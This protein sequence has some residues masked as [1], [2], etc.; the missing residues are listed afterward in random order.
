MREKPRA[1]H[2]VILRETPGYSI[3]S[4]S[5]TMGAPVARE[6]QLA[7]GGS[8]YA[9]RLVLLP[10]SQDIKTSHFPLV[11]PS[12]SPGKTPI[13][14]GILLAVDCDYLQDG[15]S[16]GLQLLH[17]CRQAVPRCDMVQRSCSTKDLYLPHVRGLDLC[18]QRL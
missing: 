15:Q 5:A 13:F 1:R 2:S 7:K 17:S 10:C 12:T 9:T 3:A 18:N 4:S 8:C 14:F 16:Y 6:P 11:H